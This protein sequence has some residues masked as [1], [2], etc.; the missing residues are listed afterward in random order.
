MKFFFLVRDFALHKIEVPI[1]VSVSITN[2]PAKVPRRG[3]NSYQ[4]EYSAT[5]FPLH[6]PNDYTLPINAL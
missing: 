3:E 4:K 5:S 6:L 2:P 1:K